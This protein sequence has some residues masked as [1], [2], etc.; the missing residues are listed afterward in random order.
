[1]KIY[2]TSDIHGYFFPTDYLDR[3]YKNTG[4]LCEA[5][6]FARDE[7]TIVI[8]GGDT[9]QGSAFDYYMKTKNNSKSIGNIMSE[10]KYD[11]YTLGNHDFNYGYEYLLNY[12]NNFNAQC[13]CANVEDTLGNIK[14]KPYVILNIE[15]KKVAITGL[16]TDWVSLW[17]KPEYLKNFKISNTFETAKKVLEEIKDAD[18]KICI[19]H[20][21]I[22]EDIH[23][24]EKLSDTDE[25][26]A[27]KMARELNFD[28]IL[29]AH[30][31]MDVPSLK[32]ENTHLVQ[33]PANGEKYIEIGI[34]L[35]DN[36]VNSTSKAPTSKPDKNIYNKFREL[37]LKTQDFLDSP[38]TTLDRDYLP[39]DKLTMAMKGSDL[40]DFINRAQIEIADADISITSFANEIK[41]FNK[42]VTIR[43]VLLTYR[44]PNTLVVLEIDG[45][46]LRAALE[47]NYTYIEY[48]NGKFEIAKKFL[49]PKVEHYN[50]D[51]FYGIEFELNLKNENY[52]KIG[53]IYYNKKLI[54]DTDT[55]KLVMNNYRSTGAGNFTMYKNLKK[56]KEVNIEVSE[57]LINYLSNLK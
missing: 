5:N 31:H 49:L 11:F 48:V 47:Q 15:G 37:D 55:F 57:L 56:V 39:E 20:G 2:F 8:D 30:Q 17:E 10:V 9:L 41:G 18:F 3:N 1:M 13:I 51:F 36:T 54:S 35:E 42:N 28:L 38:L 53:D 45:K 46:N 29:T 33:C 32:I 14:I 44:F 43:D 19:Y 12:T 26:I 22:E 52:N 27:A 25:N 24:F 40:A 34:N 4:L 21:G 50:F 7:N 16:V 23:T 6:S